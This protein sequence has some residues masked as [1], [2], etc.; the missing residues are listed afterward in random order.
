MIVYQLACPQ[1]HFFEGWFASA[2]ACEKQAAEGHLSCPTCASGEIRK[3]PAA[4]YVKGSSPET[5]PVS[6]ELR[7]KVIAALRQHLLENTHDVG[8][9][10]AE[11]ARRIHYKEEEA[12]NIRGRATVEEALE[13]HE[14]GIEAYVVPPGVIAPE[15]VH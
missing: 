15:E 3:L 13:L 1:D 7:A 12:R 5:P 14:E 6:P 2:D 4:P 8:R 10:F 11:V 9:Q